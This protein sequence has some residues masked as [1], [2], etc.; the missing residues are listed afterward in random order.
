M[1]ISRLYPNVSL[2]CNHHI[3]ALCSNSK[4]VKKNDVFYAIQGENSDGNE[5][6]EEAI[7]NG[8]KTIIYNGNINS[9]C[10]HKNINYI[11]AVNVRK[12][13]A[14][15]AKRFFHDISKNIKLIG[16][17]GTNG[18]T[19]TTSLFYK[20]L[21]TLKKGVTL[22]G[23]NGAYI[24]DEYYETNNTTP[25]IL[26]IYT[27]FKKTRRQK[28]KYV[29]MEVSSHA[30]KLLR[31]WGLNFHTVLLTNVTSD[32]LDFHKTYDDYLYT[33]G[34]FLTG[35]H[36][37]AIINTETNDFDFL[38]RIANGKIITFGKNSPDFKMDDIVIGNNYTKFKVKINNKEYV[39][40]TK[41]LAEFN[42]YNITGFLAILKT[43]NLFDNRV[44]SF[45]K[46]DIVV[47]GR[48]E[49]IEKDGKNIYVDFAHTPDGVLKVLSYINSVKSN[50]LITVLGCGGNRDKEKRP[51][52]GRIAT[53]LSDYVIFTMDSPRGE[54]PLDIINEM[55][56]GCKTNNY[57]I[58]E[59]RGEAIR[60]ALDIAK[61]NDSIAIL[62]KGNENYIILD[63]KKIEFNDRKAVEKYLNINS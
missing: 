39:V 27:I 28:I 55:K 50:N 25:S 30:I 1:K 45:L 60:V 32:H 49:I 18:K 22:I 56:A 26:E 53:D 10:Y 24:N 33:K 11:K 19:T 42:V 61:T 37:Y 62:G 36:K 48:M 20:Y 41:M 35:C 47:D 63:G 8:A 40:E 46:G 7:Y 58:I 2:N 44:F 5:Y 52:M 13:L 14:N 34:L 17:T 43:Q 3:G 21:R 16:V 54:R 51:M 15:D 9:G 57:S 4:N 38:Y 6:I 31:V 59:N 23:S 29:I 12:Q